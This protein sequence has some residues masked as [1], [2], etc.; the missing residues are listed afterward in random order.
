M[1]TNARF[2]VF[3]VVKFQVEVFWVVTPCSL[4]WDTDVSDDLAALK[5]EAK[6]HGVTTQKTS[7]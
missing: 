4:R 2:E 1:Y 6:L 3:T 5:M 7:I